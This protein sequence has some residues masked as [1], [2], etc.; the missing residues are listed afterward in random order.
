MGFSP[1]LSLKRATN[2]DP[3]RILD[4]DVFLDPK[5][6]VLHLGDFILHQV[7]IEGVDDIIIR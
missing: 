3:G 5:E 4:L 6:D 7:L 2:C 1:S